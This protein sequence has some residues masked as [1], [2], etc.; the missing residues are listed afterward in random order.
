MFCQSGVERC[1]ATRSNYHSARTF[2]TVA[3]V[4]RWRQVQHDKLAITDILDETPNTCRFVAQGFA[5]TK[6]QDVVVTMGSINQLDRLFAGQILRVNQ[7]YF[8]N[9]ALVSNTFYDVTAIDYTYLL[10]RRLVS[11]RYSSQSATTIAKDLI[12]SFASGFTS[13]NVAAGLPTIDEI[14][15]TFQSISEAL[16][17]LTKRVGGYWY[18]DYFKDLH[19]FT[20]VESGLTQPTN[21]TATH[22]SLRDFRY[23][24]DLS[25]VI[26]R[27]Y[28]EGGGSEALTDVA[29][30]AVKI[31]V[32]DG[33]WYS[34][35]GGSVTSG[36]QRV[37]YTG[38]AKGYDVN[39][40]ES[41]TGS[42][43]SSLWIAVAW[44]QSLGLLAAVA[45]GGQVMTS[46]DGVTWTAR[47]SAAA[48][49]WRDIC[50]SPEL[51]LFVAVSDTGTN[52]VMTSP[53]G[54]VW[55][56]RSAAAANLWQ[57]V[58]WSPGLMLFV[59]VS[60]DGASRVMTSPDGI[61][62]TSRTAASALSWQKVAWS[63]S[64]SLFAAV[65][66]DAG[67]SSVMTSPDGTNWTTRTS[68][69]A[70]WSD[71][72]WSPEL[73]MF[74]AVAVAGYGTTPVMTSPNG[75]TWTAQSADGTAGW[76]RI[77]WAPEA[78]VF[79]AIARAGTPRAMSSP[80]GINWTSEDPPF[81]DW[82]GLVWAPA[83][84]FVAVGITGK[85]MQSTGPD[86]LIGIP[87]S[88]VG[89]VQYAI[90]QSDSVNLLVQ[91]D[92]TSAQTTLAGL[93]GGDGVQEEYL[94]DRRLSITEATARGQATLALRSA[95]EASLDYNVKDKN[96]RS[97]KTITVSLGAPT[98][99]TGDFKIQQVVISGFSATSLTQFPIYQVQASSTRF[100]FED[101][102]RGARK[103]IS[104]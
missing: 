34:A 59:A 51:T 18:V 97:G 63:P 101:L 99:V 86:V 74:A 5:P 39:T 12:A 43:G 94:Q 102:L 103:E 73:S 14:T 62:W 1:G 8:E 56:S 28:I 100:S 21:L 26:T 35:S 53:D 104:L 24:T 38:V 57:G 17:N 32:T 52:R 9:P 96:T 68:T 48:N 90:H 36:P 98:S 76:S 54:I 30:G 88:G 15:F 20:G 42:D 65:A 25:Q 44:A 27:V 91:V 40:W 55:T 64:L 41:R 82:Y 69:S 77:R 81:N 95:V 33:S 70:T 10:N 60:T 78:G 79:A 87:A 84:G 83:Y 61:A 16:T 71:I 93:I 92:N 85:V 11:K 2:L 31:P 75:T 67:T 66:S 80:D 47:T 4:E 50:W 3:G 46:P 72:C 89:S 49:F 6:G 7:M 22:A 37:T 13:V 19:L 45:V 23:D 58:A 29:I